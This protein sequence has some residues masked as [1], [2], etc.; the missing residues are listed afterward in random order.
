[1]TLRILYLGGAM[2]ESIRE[3]I[4]SIT[5]E[6]IRDIS[7]LCYHKD[8]DV[9]DELKRV[10]KSITYMVEWKCIELNNVVLE[11]IHELVQDHVRFKLEIE[12][13]GRTSFY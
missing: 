10:E 1:M 5:L 7:D 6:H 3:I 9:D 13:K 12:Y 4:D 8:I 2:E 11:Y